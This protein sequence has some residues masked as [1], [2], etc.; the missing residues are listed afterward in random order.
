M[1]NEIATHEGR[2]TAVKEGRV[3]VQIRSVSACASCQAHG[4]CGFADAKDKTLDIPTDDWKCYTEGQT[5]S[6]RISQGRGL[7]AVW[8]AYI[9]PALLLLGVIIGLSLAG[10]SEPVVIGSTFGVLALY[11]LALYILR[12]RINT[13]FT[14]QITPNPKH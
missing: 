1:E 7:L 2:V 8:I 9:L 11:V 5:V 12:H 4:K 14:L 10:L 3:T 6:V 13:K